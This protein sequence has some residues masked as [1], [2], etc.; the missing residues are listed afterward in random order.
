MIEGNEGVSLV[1][2]LARDIGE[3]ELKLAGQVGDIG[4]CYLCSY[5]IG[6][7]VQ[8]DHSKLSM[9]QAGSMGRATPWTIQAEG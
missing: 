9:R 6:V 8:S 3:A 5:R 7:H 4:P 1:L 2:Q